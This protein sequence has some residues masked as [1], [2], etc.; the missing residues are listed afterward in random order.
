MLGGLQ[1]PAIIDKKRAM[2]KTLRDA[3]NNDPKLRLATEMLGPGSLNLKTL[4]RSRRVQPH[5]VRPTKGAKIQLRVVRYSDDSRAVGAGI[6]Q[7]QRRTSR[8][9]SEAGLDSLKLQLFSEAP[10]TT[11]WIREA[12]RF[13]GIDD[14]GHG[15]GQ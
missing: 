6:P 15:R 8:E 13:A 11:T 5:R 10:F 9:F 4:V 7:A 12:G 3:V 2:E 1:D 14:G